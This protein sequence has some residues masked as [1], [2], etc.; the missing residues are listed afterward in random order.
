MVLTTVCGCCVLY[1]PVILAGA[2]LLLVC[3]C[4]SLRDSLTLTESLC[5]ATLDT[6]TMKSHVSQ[7]TRLI[8]HMSS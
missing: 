5:L 6:M 7:P 8:R 3:P 1:R 4:V 2:P